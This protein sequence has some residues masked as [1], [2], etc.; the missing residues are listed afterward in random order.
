[1]N[2]TERIQYTVTG[3]NFTEIS[4]RKG[5]IEYQLMDEL[6]NERSVTAMANLNLFKKI[7]SVRPIYHRELPLVRALSQANLN[8]S[9][10]V[11][12]TEFNKKHPRGSSRQQKISIPNVK[13]K[14]TG[15]TQITSI[16]S[17]LEN[18]MRFMQLMLFSFIGFAAL[19]YMFL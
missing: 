15:D 9:I 10:V 3:Y 13:V 16:S 18:K 11:D 1:M 17:V 12:F 8:D 19:W 5:S 6:G 2:Q 7:S 14:G 4:K